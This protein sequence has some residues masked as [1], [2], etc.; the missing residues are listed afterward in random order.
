MNV[1]SPMAMAALIM[2]RYTGTT[3]VC[4]ATILQA[5]LTCTTHR[6]FDTMKEN[7]LKA[8]RRN[9][10]LVKILTKTTHKK[11]TFTSYA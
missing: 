4:T 5:T 11:R 9:S 7:N 8:N 6:E 2:H 1:P 3:I 10:V